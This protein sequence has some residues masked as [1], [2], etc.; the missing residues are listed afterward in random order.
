[1]S[2]NY[3][4]R[5][6]RVFHGPMDL[7]L[8]LVREQEVEIHE[9]QI[10]LIVDGFLAYVE[11]MEALDLEFAADFVLMAATLMAVKSRSLLPREEVELEDDDLDPG[12]ELIQRLV[13]YRRFKE[14]SELLERRFLDRS[15]MWSRG[16]RGEVR[17][18]AG[19]PTLELGELDVWDLF[20]TYSRLMRETRADQPH[21]VATDPRPLRYYVDQVVQHVRTSPKLS[22]RGLLDDLEDGPSRETLVGS[23]CALLEL[24]RVGVIRVEQESRGTDISIQ[25]CE[26]S[27]EEIEAAL[28]TLEAEGADETAEPGEAGEAAGPAPEEAEAGEAGEIGEAEESPRP[29]PGTP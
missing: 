11:T 29:T 8:H 9:V 23:F 5:L 12:D 22:L 16:W 27:D 26:G 7:L 3:T 4:V 25:L 20:T 28:R 18:H 19:E 6:D 17:E 15:R 13:E 14:S 21:R 10:S 2:A 24:C 1:M